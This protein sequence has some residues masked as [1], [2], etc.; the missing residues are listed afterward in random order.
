M[1]HVA[2]GAKEPRLRVPADARRAEMRLILG[3]ACGVSGR[4]RLAGDGIALDE[5]AAT[6]WA[7]ADVAFACSTC[8][9]ASLASALCETASAM[10]PGSFFIT[11]SVVFDDAEGWECV[12]ESLQAMSWGEATV[13]IHRRRLGE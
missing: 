5:P 3:D 13:Y 6:D 11:T 4:P 9:S 1:P 8:F 7:T 12:D 2:Q 10:R